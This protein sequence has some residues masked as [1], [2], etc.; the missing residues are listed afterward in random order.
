MQV[1]FIRQPVY[2]GSLL[3]SQAI[4][5]IHNVKQQ[6]TVQGNGGM[7]TTSQKATLS[8]YREVWFHKDAITNVLSHKNMWENFPVM[9][10]G[11]GKSSTFLCVQR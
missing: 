6:M 8:S 3:Q 5:N 9:Y 2:S 1:Y 4:L 10:D 11:D 7:L